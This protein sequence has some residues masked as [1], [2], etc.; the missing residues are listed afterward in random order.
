MKK[1]YCAIFLLIMP[2][3]Y[4]MQKKN[5]PSKKFNI[6]NIQRK[7]GKKNKNQ[8][9]QNCNRLVEKKLDRI[10][11]KRPFIV[12]AMDY[13]IFLTSL[14]LTSSLTPGILLLECVRTRGEAIGCCAVLNWCR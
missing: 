14:V 9:R 10:L 13:N 3:I 8:A 4:G 11:D 2:S 1:L 6:H 7:H 12:R 5:K